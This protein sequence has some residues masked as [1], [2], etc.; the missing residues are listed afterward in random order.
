MEAVH[1][2]FELLVTDWCNYVNGET[3]PYA[4]YSL[5]ADK[6]C[7]CEIHPWDTLTGGV[8]SR[9]AD[10]FMGLYYD[11]KA[12]QSL[13]VEVFIGDYPISVLHME[14]GEKTLAFEGVTF[15]SLVSLHHHEVRLRPACLSSACHIHLIYA[16]VSGARGMLATKTLFFVTP[17]HSR[18]T[19]AR[20]NP[21]LRYISGMAWLDDKE[22]PE[23]LDPLC[24]PQFPDSQ[25]KAAK[26]LATQQAACTAKL[27]HFRRELMESA[28]HPRR[29][30]LWCV[31]T[32]DAEDLQVE[33]PECNSTFLWYDEVLV[34]S[35]STVPVVNS[36]LKL[37]RH[38][39]GGAHLCFLH[40]NGR[41]RIKIKGKEDR[42]LALDPTK[43]YWTQGELQTL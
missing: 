2:E 1:R 15:I 3:Q 36:S 31:D 6:I 18:S 30:L 10:I 7:T 12:S 19:R 25:T 42:W 24:L 5:W 11:V 38:Q 22:P 39:D 43:P 13:D 27:D 41:T 8:V 32:E 20:S 29:H 26:A 21:V 23:W 35:S 17:E 4:G 14:P 33:R 37:V 16:N 40:S 34:I 9:H 28:W